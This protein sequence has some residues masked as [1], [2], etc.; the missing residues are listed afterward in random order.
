MSV[1][2]PRTFSTDWE[3]MLVDRF[4][5]VVSDAKCEAFASVLTAELDLP[6]HVDW[7]TVEF[8]MGINKSFAQF[9]ERTIR[10]TDAAARLV[11]EY[12]LHLF[13]AAAHPLG[14]GEWFN[15]A[16]LHVGSLHDDT[17]GLHL[18]NELLR[19]TPA[20]G[21]LAAN[22][23]VHN[24]CYLE[25]KSYRIRNQAGGATRPVTVRQADTG[26]PLWGG[27]ASPKLF[28]HPTLEVRII[29]CASSR[30]F[31]SELATFVAAYLH[32]RGEK[33]KPHQP[34][35][36]EYLDTMVNRWSAAKHGMQ[37]SFHWN[38]KKLPVA[39]ILDEM[40]DECKESLAKLGCKRSDL[41]LINTMLKKRLCQADFAAELAGRYPDPQ[42]FSSAYAKLLRHFEIVDEW[43]LKAKPLDPI[44]A[45]CDDTVIAEHLSHI[46]E[47]TE[48]SKLREV[49]CFPSP[50][51]DELYAAMEK[52]GL[53]EKEVTKAHGVLLNR[54]R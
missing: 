42:L 40:L 44:A 30:Q 21:A 29:D 7:N 38:G 17:Q 14:P 23:P 11:G 27:D 48:F 3:V 45:P 50:A 39:S 43:L 46:G 36:Q 6:I 37:A 53:V 33:V 9:A 47:G 51:A 13:P 24:K 4:D 28:T 54:R 34:G 22:S 5:R 10:A 19:Y 32:H 15:A 18:E 31:L 8:G 1:F 52:R 49:M 25:Y 2:K 16:H 12:D 20:F 41:V 35:K 26:Q